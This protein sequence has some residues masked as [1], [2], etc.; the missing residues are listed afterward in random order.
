MKLCIIFLLFI[1]NILPLKISAAPALHLALISA[2]ESQDAFW[3]PVEE[4]AQQAAQQLDIKL[5]IL[6][7]Y[8]SKRNMLKLIK[9]AKALNIDAVI[10]ANFGQIAPLLLQQAEDNK[11]PVMLFNS[12]I[13]PENKKLV[14]KPREKFKYWLMSLIPDDQ[15]AGYLLG[16]ALIAEARRNN[17]TNDKNQVEIIAINGTIT[18][19]PAKLRLQGLQQ[20]IDEDGNS[21]LLQSVYAHWLAES[22][23]YKAAH[24]STRYPNAKVFWAASDLM[25]IAIFDTLNK[26]GL[27]QGKDFITG[28]VDWSEQGLTAIQQSKMINSTGGHFMDAAWAVIMLYDHFNGSPLSAQN[29]YELQSPM[30]LI[31]REQIELLL[32]HMELKNWHV[33]NFRQRSK[34]INKNLSE[35][36]FSPASI[37]AELKQGS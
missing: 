13:I 23:S 4:F 25:A 37:L 19:T 11:L 12:D 17:F 8:N 16:Q 21:V 1:I 34:A 6:Y 2:R 31:S 7:S 22:A 5:T 24:L 26:K 35:Y 27:I 9:Q 15:Q 28:G 10:F 36:N 29:S 20:A 14:G 32:P 30:S 3:G 33:I 18:D